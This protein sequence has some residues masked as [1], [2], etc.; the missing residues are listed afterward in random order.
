MMSIKYENEEEAIM[1]KDEE[2]EKRRR[3]L[4]VVKT[5]MITLQSK[6][7]LQSQTWLVSSVKL[8]K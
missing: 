2:K 7:H 8:D 3:N 5:K 1:V 4:P 6:S